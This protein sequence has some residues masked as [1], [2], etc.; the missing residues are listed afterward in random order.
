MEPTQKVKQ[1]LGEK[2]LKVLQAPDSVQ[3]IQIE[4]RTGVSL[5]NIDGFKIL[6]R[7]PMLS[8]DQ[9]LWLKSLIMDE[10]SYDFVNVK[11]H[12]MDPVIAYQFKKGT[13]TVHV[14]VSFAGN[15]WQFSGFDQ[16]SIEDNDPVRASLVALAK[17]LFPKDKEI[18]ALGDKP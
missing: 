13:D 14:L 15:L 1:F 18:Q 8:G 7:G 5:E 2:M 4:P 10:K 6:N 17:E 16:K 9:I 11:R 12:P 3:A